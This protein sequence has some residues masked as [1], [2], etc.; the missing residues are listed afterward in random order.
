MII[1]RRWIYIY[2]YIIYVTYIY[3]ICQRD[4]PEKN[5]S[6]I[7][8]STISGNSLTTGGSG[9]GGGYRGQVPPPPPQYLEKFIDNLGNL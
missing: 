5:T 2:I 6:K 3:I 4:W 8:L 1:I 7:S 9:G